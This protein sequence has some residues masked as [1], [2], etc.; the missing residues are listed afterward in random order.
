MIKFIVG[1]FVGVFIM[2]MIKGGKDEWKIN[3]K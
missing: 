3:L 1:M 2:C